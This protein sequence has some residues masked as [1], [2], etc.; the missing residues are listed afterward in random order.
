MKRITALITVT[1]LLCC[2]LTAV[3]ANGKTFSQKLSELRDYSYELMDY[4]DHYE[5]GMRSW[6]YYSNPTYNEVKTLCDRIKS[7]KYETEE[8]VDSDLAVIAEMNRTATVGSFELNEV[9]KVLETESNTAGYYDDDIW[10]ETQRVLRE[11][12]SAAQGTDYEAVHIAYINACNH[13][14]R[15]ALY[16][17]VY[18][19]VNRDGKL[20]I[21][22]IT[23]LQKVIAHINPHLNISQLTAVYDGTYSTSDAL[24]PNIQKVTELQKILARLQG[25]PEGFSRNVEKIVSRGGA[26]QYEPYPDDRR[27]DPG[28]FMANGILYHYLCSFCEC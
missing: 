24:S 19:D 28:D 9:I 6:P 16:N 8:E 4:Y 11:A 13:I 7:H 10:A 3:T 23:Y 18:G 17:T 2:S 25:V 20:T 21:S 22:D 27:I 26:N 5:E 14:N 12:Q 15:I 1:V